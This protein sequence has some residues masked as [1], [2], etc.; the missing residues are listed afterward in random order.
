MTMPKSVRRMVDGRRVKVPAAPG[1]ASPDKVIEGLR[2]EIEQYRQ[3]YREE[4]IKTAKLKAALSAIRTVA[5][6]AENSSLDDIPF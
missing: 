6:A 2:V 5:D 3:W 4:R 1:D